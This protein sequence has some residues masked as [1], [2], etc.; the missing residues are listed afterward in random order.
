MSIRRYET[1]IIVQI[2]AARDEVKAYNL[3]GGKTDVS[4]KLDNIRALVF[5]SQGYQHETYEHATMVYTKIDA[6]IRSM[7]KVTNQEYRHFNKLLYPEEFGIDLD[8]KSGS[9]KYDAIEKRYEKNKAKAHE[10]LEK[11]SDT[12]IEYINPTSKG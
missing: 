8:T 6:L 1:Q 3:Y 2:R 12:L 5:Q 11:I 9:E 7:L 4:Q 10:L